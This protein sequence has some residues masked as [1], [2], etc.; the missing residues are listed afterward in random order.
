MTQERISQACIFSKCG[1]VQLRTY[2]DACSGRPPE[3]NLILVC[4]ADPMLDNND[5][6]S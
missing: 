3:S 6:L 5:S 2:N 4:V 1:L